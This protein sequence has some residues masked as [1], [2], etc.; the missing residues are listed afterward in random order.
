MKLLILSLIMISF[1][2]ISGCTE[3]TDSSVFN[4]SIRSENIE[5]ISQSLTYP[6]YLADPH[7]QVK[8]LQ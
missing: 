7:N 5:I 3:K 8:S 1:V 2:V 4:R 6:A